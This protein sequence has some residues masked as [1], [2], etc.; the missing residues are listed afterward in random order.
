V[1]GGP[2]P[3]ALDPRLALAHVAARVAAANPAPSEPWLAPSRAAVALV[4]REAA[5]PRDLE[6]LFIRRA[7]DPRDRWS[8]HMALPGG[9][10]EAG[11]ASIEETA[12]RETREEVGVDVAATGRRLGRL[13]DERTLTQLMVVSPVVY[14]IAGDPALAPSEEVAEALWVPLGPLLRGERDGTL[15]YTVA[16]ATVQ[17]PCWRHEGCVIWGLT[18]KIL[19]RFF[20][21]L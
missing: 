1:S 20:D 15:P 5:P 12:E 16:G 21:L 3:A 14:A 6:A 7:E 17:L 18:Y 11:D 13:A 2:A 8:G 10:R 9:R 19:R 4:L